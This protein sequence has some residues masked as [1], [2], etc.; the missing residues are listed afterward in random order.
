[1]A[2]AVTVS[3]TRT[4]GGR[5]ARR[6][7]GWRRGRRPPR[8]AGQRAGEAD[9]PGAAARTGWPTRPARSTPRWPAPHRVAGGS[10]PVD[11]LGT[12]VER[13]HPV[14]RRGPVGGRRDAGRGRQRTRARTRSSEEQDPTAG[15]GGTDAHAGSLLGRGRA[16]HRSSYAWGRPARGATWGRSRAARSGGTDRERTIRG[17]PRVSSRIAGG[18]PCMRVVLRTLDTAPSRTPQHRRG[19]QVT[20]GDVPQSPPPGGVPDAPGVRAGDT[21]LPATTEATRPHGWRAARAPT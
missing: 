9:R 12:R 19:R 20:A 10:K 7:S 21:R 14:G 18:N 5:P 17:W 8:P 3:P 1:M 4:D 11:D 2:P 15:P 6:S 13:P 16:R